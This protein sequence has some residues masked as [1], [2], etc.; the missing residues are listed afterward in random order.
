M[1]PAV[2]G[3]PTAVVLRG[4]HLSTITPQEPAAGACASHPR[5]PDCPA[6]PLR[7]RASAIP[8]A[9]YGSGV[10]QNSVSFGEARLIVAQCSIQGG[11]LS[12]LGLPASP[13]DCRSCSGLCQ[14]AA[15]QRHRYR[16]CLLTTGHPNRLE[17]GGRGRGEE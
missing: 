5:L 9:L 16:G 17:A 12:R 7:G 15:H 6:A 8:H 4:S 1:S 13:A 10:V 14:V 2:L 3:T 11:T